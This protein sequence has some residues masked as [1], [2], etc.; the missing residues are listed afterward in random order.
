[1]GVRVYPAII[2]PNTGA[3]EYVV[4]RQKKNGEVVPIPRSPRHW[5]RPF[6]KWADLNLYPNRAHTP[7]MVDPGN[8][9]PV[10]K[11]RKRIFLNQL[12]ALGFTGR[13]SA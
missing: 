10:T 3:A 2:T 5:P 7:P 4:S 8:I 12:A 13:G 11:I 9:F 6:L 1:L